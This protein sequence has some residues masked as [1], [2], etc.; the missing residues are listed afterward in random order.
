MVNYL[1]PARNLF[2]M[3][4]LS[5]YM[6][7]SFGQSHANITIPG[8]YESE[9]Q[10]CYD[11]PRSIS[12]PV[13]Q[14][15]LRSNTAPTVTRPSTS[16]SVGLQVSQWVSS[17]R[18]FASR[19]SSRASLHTLSKPRRSHHKP[20]PSIGH[21][22]NFQRVE[23]VDG[24]QSML[25]DA[26]MPIRRRRSFRPLE[27][28]IYEEDGRL[29]PLPDFSEAEREWK[30]ISANIE[31]PAQAL[32]REHDSRTNSISSDPSTSAYLI[33][34]KPVGS[35][36]RRSSVQSMTSTRPVSA[37]LSNL[38][39][40]HEE[41]SRP[42]SI[43]SFSTSVL[44]PTRILSR[45]P[46]PSRSRSSS[47]PR[48]L[49]RAKTD[50]D[51]E[52]KALNTIVE[53]RRA[54]A[55]RTTNQS[56]AF[57]NRPPPSPSHHV[58]TVAPSLRLRCRAETL[59]DIGSA[60][61]KPLPAPPVPDHG[62]LAR[63]GRLTLAPPAHPFAPLASNPITPPDN[64]TPTPTTPI[65]RLGAWFKRSLPSSPT[66]IT[67]RSKPATPV[68]LESFYRLNASVPYGTGYEL[69]SRPSTAGSTL[70][71]TTHT[72]QTSNE[73]ATVTL[74]SS[75]PSTPALSE[76]S[77]SPTSYTT[78]ASRSPAFPHAEYLDLEEKTGAS[79]PMNGD[80]LKGPGKMRRIPA[81][82]VLRKELDMCIEAP[83]MSGRS[84]RTVGGG[85]KP[86]MSPNYNILSG[87]ERCA[88]GGVAGERGSV[89]VAF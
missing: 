26:P 18:D 47:R 52:I 38:P 56:P 84:V 68:N 34:R 27:L 67:P 16:H 8:Q 63:T 17:S 24:I 35:S 50:I 73:T 23:S 86:P 60:F 87:M 4:L 69:D 71:N 61:S 13:V 25:D 65:A 66:T 64:T 77:L 21:P 36:S 3:Y 88:P 20:R 58:P 37:T 41:R 81:P 82:L 14:S 43:A 45:L 40:L 51:E 72:R 32:I 78:A 6:S 12:P 31:I 49:R 76:R 80:V 54:D 59:S 74:L 7:S 79:M 55:Y 62:L 85:L 70:H 22:M 19:A 28:S 15:V 42:S 2:P 46:S 39:F 44:S 89:G 33:Q 83:L 9:M 30:N 1:P 5:I 57:I 75:Y 53:E 29:S 11:Q 48:S 10:I